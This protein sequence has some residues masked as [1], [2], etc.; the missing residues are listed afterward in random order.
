VSV[1][2]EMAKKFEFLRAPLVVLPEA[3][4]EGNGDGGLVA[5]DD[6]CC[7]AHIYLELLTKEAAAA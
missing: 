6:F 2:D 7:H 3:N 1:I 4:A 5:M